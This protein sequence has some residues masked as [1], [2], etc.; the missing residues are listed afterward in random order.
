MTPGRRGNRPGGRGGRQ[1]GP[2]SGRNQ[3]GDQVCLHFRKGKCSYGSR[4]KYS[5]D[6]SNAAD[7]QKP[8]SSRPSGLQPDT[9][10]L[11]RYYEWK[12]LVRK[13]RRNAST[14]LRIWEGALT[15]LDG[16][17]EELHQLVA[18]DL[19]D[20][21]LS[22]QTHIAQAT[23]TSTLATQADL[24]C[25]E[26]FLRLVT[27]PSLLGSLSIDHCLGTMYT[28]FSGTNGEEGI[29][30]LSSI[31]QQTLKNYDYLTSA[32]GSSVLDLAKVISKALY[33]LLVK[34]PRAQFSD[35]LPALLKILDELV[36]KISKSSSN[37]D[38]DALQSRLTIIKRVIAG[39]KA[40]LAPVRLFPDDGSRDTKS[41]AS[42]FP[43]KAQTPGGRHDNDFADISEISILPT[44]EEVTSDSVEYLPS[45]NFL[46]PHVLEDPM[47][48]YIDST[49]RL[50]RHDIIGPVSDVLRDLLSSKD[51]LKGQLSGKDT[52]AQVYL[53]STVRRISIEEKQGLEAIVSFLSPP[54][55]RKKTP[56]EQRSWWQASSRLGEGTLVC[57]V[58][59]DGDQK[60]I[61]FLQVTAKRAEGSEHPGSNKSSLVSNG[62][63]LP[64]VTVKLAAHEYDDL[65][66]L[67]QLWRDKTP[68]VL[69][70]F[71]GVI[72]DTFMPILNN[73]KKIKRENHIAFQKWILPGASLDDR[74]PAPLYARK[75]GFVFPLGCITKNE[76]S[77]LVLD[78]T[79]PETM[80]LQELEDATGLDHGQC[81]GLLGALTREY[82][83][84]QGPPGTGKSYL[85][86][87]LLRV[88]LGVK[89]QAELGPILVICYTNHALDQ[90]LKHLLDVGIDAI[91]RIGGRSVA[92][93][94]SG[95]NLRVVSKETPKTKVE[96]STI[97][98][99]FGYMETRM[100]M[101]RH[102]MGRWCQARTGPS[103]STLEKFLALNF[104]KI[105]VQL[106]RDKE[107]GFQIVSQDPLIAWLG[108]RPSMADVKL[109]PAR[110]KPLIQRAE[111]DIYCLTPTER[112]ALADY[113]FEQRQEIQIDVIF[114]SIDE[115]DN[116]RKTINRT[117]GAVDQRTIAKA[118][119][120]G[121]TTTSLAR[122]I[123]M[124][125]SVKPK[126]VIVEEAG[127]LKEADII[128]AL[129]PGVEHVI[130]IGDHRQLRPQINNF[131]LSLESASGKMWQL[132]RSQFERRAV[133]EPGLPPAPFA[134]LNVQRR[135]RP[136]ISR[137]IRRVYPNL[138]DHES[139]M[140]RP[141]VTGMR[142]N[143][144]WLD[145]DRMEDTGDDGTRVK[146][147]SHIWETN[148]ATALVRHL[149]RQGEYKPEDIALLTP[150]TGQ[151][152]Q[153]RAA[154]GRDFEICLSDRDLDR[155][156]QEGF[157]DET[158]DGSSPEGPEKTIEKKQLLQTIRLATVDNF[159]GEEAKIIIVSLVRSN[160]QHKV[161]FLRTENRINVLLSRAKHGMYLIGNSKTY[162]NVPMWADVHGQ[163]S[164]ADA[165]G[166]SLELCCPRHP[167][168]VIPCAEPEDFAIKSP[169]GGC[170]LPCSRR[171]EPCGHRC[172]ARCH[173]AA[174]HGVFSIS[175]R[176]PLS[177]PIHALR[178]SPVATSA[179]VLVTHVVKRIIVGLPT[180]SA[181]RCVIGLLV[182]ATIGANG[183]AMMVM[184]VGAARHHVRSNAHTPPVPRHATK[185]APHA[186]RNAPGLVLTKCPSFCGEDCPINYCQECG[187]KGDARIDLLEF[188]SYAEVDLN[189]N[190]VVVLGCGHFFTGETLD[191]LVGLDE[192][193]TRD[194][195]GNF[196]GLRD[197]SGSLAR[198]VPFCP[199][200]KRPIRQFATKRYNRLL[201]RAV[202]DEICKRFLIDG[203]KTLDSLG[204]NLQNL[205]NELAVTR[206]P[207]ATA[208]SFPKHRYLSLQKL[209]STA[210]A[211]GK[212]MDASHEPTKMLIDAIATSRVLATGDSLTITRQMEALKLSLP[213]PDK[214]IILGAQLVVIKAQEVQL[215]DAITLL[216]AW[217]GSL[218]DF[219]TQAWVKHNSLPNMKRFF[220]DCKGLINQAK[221]ANLSRT[222]VAATLAFARVSQLL[223]W[224]AHTETEADET[225]VQGEN[226]KERTSMARELLNDALTQCSRF[227]NS[228]D[229]KERVQEMIRLCEP[230]YETVTPEELA[231]I[232]S[233]MV[234]GAQGIATHSGHWY[235]C[236][237]GHP[238]AIGEC[239]MPMEVAR[240]PECGARIGGTEHQALDG[241]TRAEDIEQA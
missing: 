29:E 118:D 51:P 91:I 186:S 218:N 130:Q 41:V 163:L 125:R 213:A 225:R 133:G 169:E 96:G 155:L 47:Q 98:Q 204:R 6:I 229:L 180:M 11:E 1:A 132:D 220:K 85:G 134:Q 205:E 156:A 54:H 158:G 160:P 34:V 87:K 215:Q 70:D 117:H 139:V 14:A 116:Q 32:S 43:K 35:S 178:Y 108:K 231:S 7:G 131:S 71:N 165:V 209:S 166:T 20:D 18:R 45:T 136:D 59:S 151:L 66:L 99:A 199:D 167:D 95:K 12:R 82:A 187:K 5:H 48:R 3:H 194:K 15:I 127:E 195:E 69:V 233:A 210:K 102:A 112:W 227:A 221:E 93:E 208:K 181:Q 184:T 153:L 144:F 239:G 223:A 72:P 192:V 145:H 36:V 68:G 49:F 235:N 128:S 182:P 37:A 170:N 58:S 185:R 110:S 219:E 238:F 78:P 53:T 19:V 114:E 44:Y 76:H 63:S 60:N 226:V 86:V 39:A 83:L 175:P 211:L 105:Y 52:Q 25:A 55:I 228:E 171:L 22:G 197:I 26:S 33:E 38:L 120:V 75:A 177:A 2:S 190:P 23:R 176:K 168:T 40:T 162:L 172:Q 46:Y 107:G 30:F 198:N 201:N 31:C 122:H 143:L 62:R 222:V 56:S 237:N 126:V 67:T 103:W 193:Y 113:W 159:Q 147:H 164:Q 84:V 183:C 188:R 123:E 88:L 8:D 150:Y 179:A 189:E 140:D 234:S 206:E 115:A 64:S 77:S 203:R 81:L 129:M 173:S 27:H 224:Q 149:V 214:Q 230:R 135:M 191:G 17:S 90:F 89:E 57:F 121:V 65:S 28:L 9:E 138:Q 61:L 100:E 119:V 79:S 106:K 104:A 101:A 236:V 174:M 217:K 200:C 196:S 212:R 241:V 152:Q 157:E 4:C 161:G 42:S 142:K 97:G 240:C 141:N 10:V 207:G 109:S 16:D 216:K 92:E 24:H 148:M 124:L 13:D 21:K 94:L 73:L 232:K 202:M 137:L 80:D 50:V 146:S 154:L 111:E 74:I